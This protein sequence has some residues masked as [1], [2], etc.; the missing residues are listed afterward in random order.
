M[1]GRLKN[2]PRMQ[3]FNQL[4]NGKTYE[5]QKETLL[6]YAQS[7]GFDRNMV[8]QFLNSSSKL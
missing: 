6:N 2:D 8:A 4:M 7:N 1:S 3:Q 5:Q